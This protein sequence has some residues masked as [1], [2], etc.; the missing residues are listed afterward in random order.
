MLTEVTDVMYLVFTSFRVSRV[1]CRTLYA[2]KHFLKE[3]LQ[4]IFLLRGARDPVFREE[5]LQA[6]WWVLRSS[7]DVRGHLDIV[8]EINFTKTN[9]S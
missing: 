9:Y 6:L 7:V 5:F 8:D 3:Q 4:E 2:K 1:L